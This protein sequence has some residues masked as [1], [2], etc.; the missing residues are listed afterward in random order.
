[1]ALGTAGLVGAGGAF[2]PRAAVPAAAP[3]ASAAAHARPAGPGR[4]Y[5][6]GDRGVEGPYTARQL[7]LRAASSGL[8]AESTIVRPELGGDWLDASAVDEVVAE[9]GRRSARSLALPMSTG[10]GRSGGPSG[11]DMFERSLD[12]A[13]ADAVLTEDE[14]AILCSLC[15]AAGLAADAAGAR[16]YVL[17]RAKAL[18]CATPAS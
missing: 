11:V 17:R 1:M 7:V 15:E 6:R 8:D 13:V 18:G 2:A 16:A 10:G 12:M 14:L 9:F 3:H 4:W 5:L